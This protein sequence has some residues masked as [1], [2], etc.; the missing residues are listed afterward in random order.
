VVIG[1]AISTNTGGTGGTG[2]SGG[3]VFT[4]G[5]ATI[6]RSTLFGNTAGMGY[7][8]APGNGGAIANRGTILL[9]NSKLSKNAAGAGAVQS[10]EPGGNGGGLYST[11]SATLIGDTL[12]LNASGDGGSAPYVDPGGAFGGPGGN[13][14]GIYSTA[15]LHVT[16]STIASNHTGQGGAN[17]QPHIG[18]AGPGVGGGLGTAGGTATLSYVTIANNSDGITNLGGTVTV[19]GTIVA[20]SAGPN[21]TGAISENTGFNLDSGSTCQFTIATDISGTDPMLGALAANGGPT[22]TQALL[23]DSPAIDHGGTGAAGCPATDQRRHI[24]PDE[25]ADSGACDVGSYES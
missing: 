22:K 18:S 14:A 3:G 13:G 7:L 11:G 15:I 16:N 2:S 17:T 25:S 19:G 4:S 9:S 24:R 23:S 21:C 20:G 1:S 12:S 6:S 8:G 10:G 5:H